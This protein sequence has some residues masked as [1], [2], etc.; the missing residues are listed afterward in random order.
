MTV[1]ELINKLSTLNPNL[2]VYVEYWTSDADNSGSLES[3][4][5]INISKEEENHYYPYQPKR[6]VINA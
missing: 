2:P 1:Q 4:G 5:C 6:I 3:Q